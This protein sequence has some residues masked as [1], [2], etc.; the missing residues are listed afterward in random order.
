[1][2]RTRRHYAHDLLPLPFTEEALSQ[3]VDRIRHIQDRLGRRILVE[4]VSS[5]VTFTHS[6]MP[7]WTFLGAVAEAADCGILL[8]VNNIYVSAVNHGFSPYDYLAG[9]P[10]DRIG[11][12]HLAGHTDAGTHLIDT[13]DHPV[14]PPVW[15]IYRD[16]VRRFG[17]ISTLVE[18]DDRIPPFEEL[19]AEADRARALEAEVLDAYAK[20]A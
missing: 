8:D 16:A 5:Y 7:E 4:N 14:P 13:H 2:G 11:Q 19:V 6:A 12:I 17:P 3:V 20:P 1:M 9:L 15:A 10:L 18:W